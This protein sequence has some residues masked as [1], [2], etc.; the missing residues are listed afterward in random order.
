MGERFDITRAVAGG[1]LIIE[2]RAEQSLYPERRF[3][4]CD[5]LITVDAPDGSGK[6]V[7]AEIICEQLALRYGKDN[8]LLVKPTRFDDSPEAR[9]LQERLMAKRDLAV[10][11]VRH[12]THFMAAV[13]LNYKTAIVPALD[14]GKIVVV[15]SSEVRSLAFMLDRG[16][17]S[18]I[19]STLRWIR[20][21]RATTGIIAGNRVIVNATPEDC[22]ANIDAR[23]KRDY[24]DPMD[25][26]EAERRLD[27]YGVAFA[28]LGRLNTDI[29]INIISVDNPR[30]EVPNIATHLDELVSRQVIPKIRL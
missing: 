23:G 5:R 8:V 21:G 28:A 13:M 17:P 26:K 4:V 10:D 22:L 3:M 16:T 7:F 11:S 2:G 18:A 1:Q 27:C 15:D 19:A 30:V 24:G 9:G 29:P 25:I 6:G 14:G 20:S 12:N